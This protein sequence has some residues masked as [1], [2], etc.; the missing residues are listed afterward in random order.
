MSSSKYSIYGLGGNGM[1]LTLEGKPL[2]SLWTDY[3]VKQGCIEPIFAPRF[4]DDDTHW[5]F[6]EM[7]DAMYHYDLVQE[8]DAMWLHYFG[9]TAPP[10]EYDH[11]PSDNFR[12]MPTGTKSKR[13][14]I[15]YLL[16]SISHYI[17]SYKNVW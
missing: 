8:W 2:S 11:D 5:R 6:R 17:R 4:A 14:K 3:E 16:H 1:T 9:H 10:P 7:R 13:G 12:P 15:A